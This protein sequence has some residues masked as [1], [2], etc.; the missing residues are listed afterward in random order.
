[1]ETSYSPHEQAMALHGDRIND[2]TKQVQARLLE[3]LKVI[4]TVCREHH[5][6][7]YL[8]AGTMLGAVRHGGFIPWDDDAD[9]GM[10]RK[11]YDTLVAHA[12]EW[13]PQGY[14]MVSGGKTE[15][16]PYHFARI[17]DANSTYMMHRAYNFVGGLPVDVF[18]L[19]GMVGPSLKRSWHYFRYR[20]WWKMLYFLHTDPYKHG[21]GLRSSVALLLRRLFKPCEVHKKMDDI[22]RQWDCE[23]SPLW[24]DH[25]YK[26]NKGIQPKENYGTPVP[27]QFEGCTLMGVARPDAY[28]R[29]LYG[30]YMEI[31]TEIPEQNYRYLDLEKPWQKYVDEQAQKNKGESK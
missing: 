31:P 24:A 28:L 25:D 29:H 3:I 17:Q 11:D 13:L 21:K 6:T 22:R 12:D 23:T 27:V 7:Y 19:D 2:E 10:P 18:P 15:G 4:D 30:N 9:I 5:L 1:M 26:P 8:L 14:E 20:K 16:Y